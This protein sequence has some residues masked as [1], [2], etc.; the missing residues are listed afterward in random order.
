METR[1]KYFIST[2]L[3]SAVILFS[4]SASAF[5]DTVIDNGDP[6][7]SFTGNWGISGGP[8][9]WDPTDPTADSVWARD[10]DTYTWTFTPTDSGYH[11]VSMWWT[12]WSSRSTS[13]PVD[14][15]FWGGSDRI[16]I[17]QQQDGGQWNFLN[18]YP[19]KAGGTYNITITSQPGPTSTNADAVQFVYQPA[20]NVA[21]VATIDSISPSPTTPG[22]EVTFV[23]HG[24]DIDGSIIGY[25]WDSNL[26][27]HLGDSA[28]F[29][30]SVPLSVGTHTIS[31]T[32][33][34]NNSE[35]RTTT[36]ILSVQAAVTEFIIDN[37][38]PGTSFTGNWGVSG[39][40][41]PWNPSNPNATSLWARDGNTYTWTFN[42]GTSANYAVYMWHTTWSSRSA[43]VPVAITHAGGT[44]T[45]TINQ[46]INGSMW[47][48]LG[49]YP[50]QAGTSYNVTITSQPGPTSTS[51][52]AVRFVQEGT[53]NSPPVAS[54]T[55]ITPTAVLPGDTIAFSGSGSDSDGSVAGYEWFSDIDG[56]LS[57]QAAFS[58]NA[59]APGTHSIFFRVR[60]NQGA[61]SQQAVRLVV[62]RDCASPIAIMLLGD[63]ITKGV[64]EIATDDLRTGYRAPLFETL[65]G[66]GYYFDF[67]G[68]RK[69]G[70]LASPSFDIDHQG[71]AGIADNE[72]AA[73]VYAW[74]TA[75]PAEIVL[76]HIGTNNFSTDP[77]D[78]EDILN[79][80]DRYEADNNKAVT[81]VLA[82]II[83][84][85][86][87]HPDT[88]VFNNNIEAM[89]LS[90]IASGDKIVIVNQESA[91]DYTTDMWDLLHPNNVGYRK[92]AA[93]WLDGLLA[94]LPACGN[95][96]PFIYSSPVETATVG[97][98]YA[99]QAGA[100]GTPQPTYSLLSSP[101]GMSIDPNTGQISW[102]PGAGQG[103]THTVTVQALNSR[104]M[105]T[106]TYSINISSNGVIIDNG[107]PGT[108]FT[109]NWGLSGGANPWNPADPAATSVWARDGD[110]YTWTFTPAVS[111]NYVLS[112]WY[113]T[114]SSRS[115]GVP[116]AIQHAGGSATV[117]I[118]QQINGGMWNV[119]GTYPF[120][121]GVSYDLTITSQPGPASTCADAVRFEL[122]T[123][124]L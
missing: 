11:D 29:T 23:G 100:L 117:T 50:F 109:G 94:L 120:Q 44:D 79:E 4:S 72:V 84:R 43:S 124:G 8:N 90:R 7:T 77:G 58:T 101:A 96:T 113:T 67:V 99:Y 103:G 76:L 102:I 121:A 45:V 118:N 74:L 37:G 60:D 33:T 104:G 3:I 95:V 48:L 85:M 88:T 56:V 66:A 70:L 49:S 106:Q 119:I 87:P 75:H 55:A 40:A 34:D 54:I 9:P 114:Y 97:L 61:W 62:V 93:R 2:L 86:T 68:D 112:M 24:E 39:A 115:A 15:T 16:F 107:D 82:K 52:D 116:L 108:S 80:I 38:D 30:T 46:Q 65:K 73:N 111:G 13:I 26:D 12:E 35:T 123:S 1:Y 20:L 18:S 22:S 110:T 31:F 83:N 57:D 81:V 105:D 69:T 71:I 10:G 51:A 64:G 36:R 19:F 25:S 98:P 41:G 32:V 59:L 122:T 92:M 6:T 14:I 63:S 17:N 42:P 27:G 47:N 53:I 28:T 89:A 5:A 78:V 91:L 21:P